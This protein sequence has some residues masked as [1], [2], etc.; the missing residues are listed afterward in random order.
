MVVVVVAV[1]TNDSNLSGGPH[2]W[3]AVWLPHGCSLVSKRLAESALLIGSIVLSNDSN[4]HRQFASIAPWPFD[5]QRSVVGPQGLDIVVS[6]MSRRLSE[7][8]FL[9]ASTVLSND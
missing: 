1:M 6:Y 3:L 4:S 8:A 5:S 9:I 2:L 7:S